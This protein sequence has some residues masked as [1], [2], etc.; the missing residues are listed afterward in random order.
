MWGFCQMLAPQIFAYF[1]CNLYDSINTWF[2]ALQ[3]FLICFYIEYCFYQGWCKTLIFSRKHQICHQQCLSIQSLTFTVNGKFNPI[4]LNSEF[5]YF[6]Y[7]DGQHQ[8]FQN[9]SKSQICSQH[10]TIRNVFLSMSF[11]WKGRS[12]TLKIFS[13]WKLSSLCCLYF[14]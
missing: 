1:F 11:Q 12:F 13:L 10:C 14:L 7:K 9:S 5:S 2:Q 8:T 4:V 3:Y 6:L